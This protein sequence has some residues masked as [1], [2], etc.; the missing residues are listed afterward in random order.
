MKAAAQL[1]LTVILGL[2]ALA[3]VTVGQ[4]LNAALLVV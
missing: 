4:A 2:L 1:A 3:A